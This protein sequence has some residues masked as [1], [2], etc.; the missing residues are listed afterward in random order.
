MAEWARFTLRLPSP[1]IESPEPGTDE[2]IV[3]PDDTAVDAPRQEAGPRR[4][5][6]S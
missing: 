4:N 3:E 2:I 5:G 1:G 6:E